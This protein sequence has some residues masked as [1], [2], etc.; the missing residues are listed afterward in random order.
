MKNMT[1]TTRKFKKH[2]RGIKAIFK[3][4]LLGLI[5]VHEVDENGFEVNEFGNPIDD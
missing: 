4:F 3:G 5:G 1:V 2:H